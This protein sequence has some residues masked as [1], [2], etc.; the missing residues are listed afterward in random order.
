[1][2]LANEEYNM[3]QI[4]AEYRM[5]LIQNIIQMPNRSRLRST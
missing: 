2:A 3:L 4:L 1:M 5:Q